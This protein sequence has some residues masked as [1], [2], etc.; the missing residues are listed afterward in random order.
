[1]K[2]Q[3]LYLCE[4]YDPLFGPIRQMIKAAGFGDAKTKFYRL[5]GIQA[6]HVSLER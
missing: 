2:A 3:R 1:M 6:L 4:G 5:H